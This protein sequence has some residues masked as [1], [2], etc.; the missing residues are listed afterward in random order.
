METNDK[1][2]E[3]SPNQLMCGRVKFLKI[4]ETILQSL[5]Y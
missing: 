3:S 2:S 4:L 1:F 5:G